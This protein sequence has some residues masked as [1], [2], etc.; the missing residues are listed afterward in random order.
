MKRPG[1]E[2]LVKWMTKHFADR[3]VFYLEKTRRRGLLDLA[4]DFEFL[5]FKPSK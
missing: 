4:K 3:T 5:Y 2:Q 1:A